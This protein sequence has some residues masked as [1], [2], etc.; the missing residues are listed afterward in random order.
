M[1]ARILVVE[2][3]VLIAMEIATALEAE[4]FEVVGPCHT[5][6]QVLDVLRQ[7]DCCDAVTLDANLHNE[8]A[9]PVARALLQLEKPFIVVSGYNANQ[10]PDALAA[11]PHVAKPMRT[12]ELI[13]GLRSLLAA[14]G[15]GGA[16]DGC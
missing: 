4:G 5:V 11:A 8:S 2:D 10:L 1:T 15:A 14:R 9:Q 16:S 13:S 12:E 3:E 6:S 7:P